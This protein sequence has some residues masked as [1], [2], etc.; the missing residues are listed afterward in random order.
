MGGRKPYSI[1]N[2]FLYLF[3]NPHNTIVVKRGEERTVGSDN[4]GIYLHFTFY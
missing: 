3:S 2:L 1:H 4:K